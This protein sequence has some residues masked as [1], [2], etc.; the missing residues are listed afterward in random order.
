MVFKNPICSLPAV[1]GGGGRGGGSVRTITWHWR[2]TQRVSTCFSPSATPIRLRL[3]PPHPGQTSQPAQPA[4]PGDGSRA[5]I[6]GPLLGPL[7]TV[8][9]P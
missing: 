2:E 5:M 6:P 1:G 4:A 8:G 7:L 3:E 9:V